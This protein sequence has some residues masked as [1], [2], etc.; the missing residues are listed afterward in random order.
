MFVRNDSKAFRFCSSKC[1]KAFKKKKNPRRTAW[2]KAFR[3]AHG[4]EM[5]NDATLAFERK[6]NVPIKTNKDLIQR[7]IRAIDRVEEI[8]ERRQLA[9]YKKRIEDASI[10]STT[11]RD[12]RELRM[13]GDMLPKEQRH[14]AERA[15]AQA[16]AHKAARESAR[17]SVVQEGVEDVEMEATE[18]DLP[19]AATAKVTKVKK[20][21]ARKQAVRA[22]A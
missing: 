13:H 8:K 5:V 1:D 19:A 2:T 10:R 12:L 16:E 22:A 17:V 14:V 18:A 20:P 3:K 4:K 15:L 11:N 21:I 9:F 6:R 7:T